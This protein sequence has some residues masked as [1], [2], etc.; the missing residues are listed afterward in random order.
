[1]NLDGWPQKKNTRKKIKTIKL[2]KQKATFK[3]FMKEMQFCCLEFRC[4]EPVLEK[5]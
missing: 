3:T 5:N 1:M 4:K 2:Q